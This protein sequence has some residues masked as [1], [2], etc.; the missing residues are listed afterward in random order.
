[1]AHFFPLVE[2][3][4][5]SYALSRHL[6]DSNLIQQRPIYVVLQIR[7]AMLEIFLVMEIF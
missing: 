1:M 6:L 3:L 7:R 2:Q 4:P 5:Y